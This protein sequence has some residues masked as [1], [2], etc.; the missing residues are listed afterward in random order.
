MYISQ[1]IT[2][3]QPR[4][5]YFKGIYVFVLINIKLLRL[6]VKLPVS[7]PVLLRLVLDS[8][9]HLILWFKMAF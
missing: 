2:G 5:F 9:F 4:R 7:L 6:F 3:V 1:Y 8:T